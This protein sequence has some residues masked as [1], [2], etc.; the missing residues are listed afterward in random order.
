MPRMTRKKPG[1]RKVRIDFRQNRQQRRRS[2]EWTRRF[3]AGDERLDDTDRAEHVRARGELSRKR[4]VIVGADDLPAVDQALWQC[5]L[6][7]GVHGQVCYVD[8][9]PGREW[10]C[11]V[12]RVLRTR[13]IAQ[14]SP[15]TVGDRVW[16]A[17]GSA[18]CG[19]ERVGVIEQVEPRTSV[20]ARRDFRR[21]QHTLVANA[22][23][24]L[25]VVSIFQPRLKPHLVD[26]Y[27]IAAEKGGL[28]P[29]LCFNKV[30]LLAENVAADTSD[31]E[32]DA[33]V[34]SAAD[35]IREFGAIGYRCLL[36]SVVTGDGL[37]ELREVLRDHVTVL[38]GQSGV[39]KSSLINALQ[40]QLRLA[41][42]EVSTES[43][44]GRHTT[45]HARLLPLDFG[46]YVVDTPG[47]RAF[48]LWNVEPGELE[49]Y[50]REFVPLVEH[51]RFADCAHRQEDGCAVR[52]AVEAGQVS[53]RRYHSYL[54]LLTEV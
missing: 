41:V 46:G 4:T 54:K 26:R 37:D 31:T 25:A 33:F 50:F 7:T 2:D 17:D 15:V 39:G 6:V 42:Q 9:A 52:A 43:E 3:Q 23:Q 18:F 8:D 36:T 51:C 24:L 13:L 27:I 11:T 32:E 34:V 30:D 45:T 29:V 20:L 12:R 5:G 22:D 10:V 21:R 1:S 19:G 16:F 47:I 49:A 44:K 48:D 38:S 53:V 28:R 35:A 14:R 40:P